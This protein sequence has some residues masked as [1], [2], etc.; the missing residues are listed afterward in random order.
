MASLGLQSLRLQVS[1][2]Y[3]SKTR[4][5]FEITI[6]VLGS[7]RILTECPIITTSMCVFQKPEQMYFYQ[8]QENRGTFPSLW[9]R[10]W[11]LVQW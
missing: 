9:I 10:A 11:Y 7:T 4:G 3:F 1:S 6:P 5:H 2:G 8:A